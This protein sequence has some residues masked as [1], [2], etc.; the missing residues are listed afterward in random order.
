MQLRQCGFLLLVLLTSI[1]GITRAQTAQPCPEGIITPA[2]T[3]D[4]VQKVILCLQIERLVPQLGTALEKILA[5]G[6]PA[7]ARDIDRLAQQVNR[8]ANQNSVKQVAL[9]QALERRLIEISRQ[10]IAEI[11]ALLRELTLS[12]LNLNA[13][14]DSATGDASNAKAFEALSPAIGDAIGRLDISVASTL[15]DQVAALRD[16]MRRIE[17]K[18]DTQISISEQ[19]AFSRTLRMAV[20]DRDQGDSGQKAALEYFARIGRTFERADLAGVNF[21]GVNIPKWSARGVDLSMSDLQKANLADA[22]LPEARLTGV[23]MQSARLENSDLTSCIAQLMDA[24]NANFQGA[25]L[26]YCNLTGA[27]FRGANL[28]GAKLVGAVLEGADLREAQLNGADLRNAYL[29]LANLLKS[30]LD[31][32]IIENT[33]SS[34]ALL[35]ASTLSPKQRLGLCNLWR[36]DKLSRKWE[37][38]EISSTRPDV[39]QRPEALIVGGEI[40]ADPGTSGLMRLKASQPEWM[41]YRLDVFDTSGGLVYP[42][43]SNT[44]GPSPGARAPEFDL[45]FPVR[46]RLRSELLREP[47]RYLAIKKRFRE[48]ALPLQSRGEDSLNL[49]HFVERRRKLNQEIGIRIERSS[50]TAAILIPD[51]QFDRRNDFWLLAHLS[52]SAL[53]SELVDWFKVAVNAIREVEREDWIAV[54]KP[55]LPRGI[56][57]HD[58]DNATAEH[59]RQWAKKVAARIKAPLRPLISVGLKWGCAELDSDNPRIWGTV[60]C[61]PDEWNFG[62]EKAGGGGESEK[63]KEKIS[64]TGRDVFVQGWNQMPSGLVAIP[65]LRSAYRIV[66]GDTKPIRRRARADGFEMLISG[67]ELIKS[68]HQNDNRVY[69][70]W[71]LVPS[72]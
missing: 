25:N 30:R 71:T 21:A 9:A 46:I 62:D 53:D 40:D 7:Q 4:T 33:A 41:S 44:P 17:G 72:P 2:R 8:L 10:S 38:L 43:C 29:S 64:P 50:P 3:G 37:F 22:N 26:S 16:Q 68:S 36:S 67:A 45:N 24:R 70:V 63:L 1:S 47:Y 5:I 55:I 13:K 27:D 15:V 66:G 28:R 57:I 18:I 19:E 34:D 14:L 58:V 39:Y 32:A 6:S 12:I 35:N 56:T 54:W 20:I 49:E 65:N 60:Q 48:I 59:F 51:G 23:N 31:G 11:G 52:P 69:I 42:D 61:R